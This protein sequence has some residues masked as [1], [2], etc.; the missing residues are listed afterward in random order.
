MI[1]IIDNSYRDVSERKEVK[2]TIPISLGDS[3]RGF[4]VMG[5]SRD[6]FVHYHYG[7]KRS[8]EFEFGRPFEDI[9][10]TQA[11]TFFLNFFE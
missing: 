7:Q 5:T 8:L 6:Y 9:F 3:H 4:R 2:W 10:D 1:K 11:F